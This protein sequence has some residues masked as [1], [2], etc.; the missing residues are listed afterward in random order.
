[1]AAYKK[2]LQLS[3]FLTATDFFPHRRYLFPAGLQK[4][5]VPYILFGNNYLNLILIINLSDLCFS[6]Y[7][8][9]ST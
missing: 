8:I 1:M 2:I 4:A 6:E 3:G 9:V 7:L 5:T